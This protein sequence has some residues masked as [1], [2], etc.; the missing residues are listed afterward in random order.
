MTDSSV[1]VLIQVCWSPF[2]FSDSD[3]SVIQGSDPAHLPAHPPANLTS[4]LYRLEMT[5][6]TMK[7][8]KKF[9]LFPLATSAA[10]LHNEGQ[11]SNFSKK[12]SPLPAVRAACF[13]NGVPKQK[14]YENY[15]L[16]PAARAASCA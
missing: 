9:N 16:Q 12:S 4:T 13:H 15:T 8:N 5:Q 6:H 3:E 11:Y 7:L 1:L 14:K 10:F 2:L